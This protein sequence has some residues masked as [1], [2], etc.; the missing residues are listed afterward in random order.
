VTANNQVTYEVVIVKGTTTETLVYDKD[1]KFVNKLVP[2][3]GTTET[4][5]VKTTTT[6]TTTKK[7]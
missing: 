4:K 6:T 3:T 2:K 5:V 7:K 1:G